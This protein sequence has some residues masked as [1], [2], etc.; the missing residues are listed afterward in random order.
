MASTAFFGG[1]FFGGEFFSTSTDA[2][3]SARPGDGGKRGKRGDASRIFKPT[4][5]LD[6][7]GTPNAEETPLER[8]IAET[9][10]IHAEVQAERKF[11]APQVARMGL[12]VEAMSLTDIDA[13]IGLLLRKTM[14]TQAE[15]IMLLILMCAA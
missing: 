2:Q 1:A 14:R 6:R 7:R 11:E 10:E 9:A 12:P 4:G 8:R 5:L 15:E 3:T 13:E